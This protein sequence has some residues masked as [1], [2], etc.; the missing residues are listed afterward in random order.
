MQQDNSGGEAIAG[1]GSRA[2]TTLERR[3]AEMLTWQPLVLSEQKVRDL[4]EQIQQFP[5]VFD[6]FSKGRYDEFVRHFFVP[7]NVFI[8]I[9]PGLGLAAGFGVRPGLDAVL[10]L[11]M[12]D[13]KLRGREPVFRSIMDHFFRKLN[14]R[15][16]SALIA[17]DCLTACKLCERLG[18]KLEGRMKK[19]ILRDGQYHDT[20]IYGILREEFDGAMSTAQSTRPAAAEAADTTG[21]DSGLGDA[22]EELERIRRLH[23]VI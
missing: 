2:G 10:H 15:R 18:F 13:R 16:M 17:D 22:T 19:S 11:V 23:T 20:M 7:T 6:D 1:N 21:S 5:Q 8:D 12:F 9:G 3:Q 14:L 4:W